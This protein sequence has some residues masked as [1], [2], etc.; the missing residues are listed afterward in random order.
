MVCIPLYMKWVHLKILIRNEIGN[1]LRS[2]PYFHSSQGTHFINPKLSDSPKVFYLLMGDSK[3]LK[4][5]V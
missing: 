5:V 4:V 2:I 1:G 3:L